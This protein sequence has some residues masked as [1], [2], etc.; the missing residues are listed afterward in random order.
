VIGAISCMLHH[1]QKTF[2][3]LEQSG[4]KIGLDATAAATPRERSSLTGVQ[5]PARWGRGQAGVIVLAIAIALLLPAVYRIGRPFLTAFVLAGILAVALNPFHVWVSRFVSRRSVTSLITTVVA[6]A[7]ILIV[8]FIAADVIRRELKSGALSGLLSTAQ[9]FTTSGPINNKLAQEAASRISQIAG[10]LFTTAL[11]LVFLYV[12]LLHGQNWL[13]QLAALLP[14]DTAVTNRILSTARD[15]IVANIDGIVAVGAAQAVLFGIIF[16]I[17]GIGSPA[18]WAALAGLASVVPVVG[19]T[20]V[21]LPMAI[22]LAMHGIWVKAVLM[23]LGC[24]V[25]QTAIGELLRPQVVGKRVRQ[26]PLLI[27]LSVLGATEAFGA[28]GILLGPVIVSVMAVL[29]AELRTQIRTS[30]VHPGQAKHQL[31]A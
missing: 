8:V 17:S 6:T 16:W 5:N 25:G 15:G 13:A 2:M 27:A 10:G 21:W 23:G 30:P 19:A 26:A 3:D 11:A 4:A 20:V 14:L 29:V 28:L 1:A 31:E 22:N 7:P 24:L 9:Q 18:P 12:L